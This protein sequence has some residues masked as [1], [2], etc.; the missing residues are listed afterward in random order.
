MVEGRIS[1]VEL[2]RGCRVE[3]GGW[4]VEG[5]VQVILKKVNILSYIKLICNANR[6]VRLFSTLS[7]YACYVS[8]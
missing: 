8:V 6:V 4:R 5:P 1:R 7:A 2:G 3:G